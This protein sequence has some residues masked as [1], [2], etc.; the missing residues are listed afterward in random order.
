MTLSEFGLIITQIENYCNVTFL[1]DISDAYKE[2]F[3]HR[4]YLHVKE[5]LKLAYINGSLD[6]YIKKRLIPSPAV[7]DA[8]YQNIKNREKKQPQPEP[9]KKSGQALMFIKI[10]QMAFDARTSKHKD[11]E[12]WA[13]KIYKEWQQTQIPFPIL[14]ESI[15]AIA[16]ESKRQDVKD[17]VAEIATEIEKLHSPPPAPMLEKE[18]EPVEIENESLF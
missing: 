16:E 1:N 13:K 14:I 15:Y 8:F 10:V 6:D 18:P 7:F 3:L 5:A 9:F 11:S 4:E 17:Y 12:V 2:A